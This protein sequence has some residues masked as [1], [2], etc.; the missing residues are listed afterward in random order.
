MRT[1]LWTL[2]LV[3]IGTVVI[4]FWAAAETRTQ[5]TVYPRVQFKAAEAGRWRITPDRQP[6]TVRIEGSSS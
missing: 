4:W 3:T 2:A 6:V 1:D 5:A